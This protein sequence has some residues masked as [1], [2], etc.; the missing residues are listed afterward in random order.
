MKSN[1]KIGEVVIDDDG[2]CSVIKD[3]RERAVA[4][5]VIILSNK[6]YG[7]FDTCECDIEKFYHDETKYTI[8]NQDGNY[9]M[10]FDDFKG[11]ARFTDNI[12]HAWTFETSDDAKNMINEIIDWTWSSQF[13]KNYYKYSIVKL[14]INISLV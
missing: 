7:T 2:D 8:M 6:K 14:D 11:F 10:E 1:F 3:I 13:D 12:T 4:S 9:Y 5:N